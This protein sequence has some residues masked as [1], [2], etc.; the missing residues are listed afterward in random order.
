L[1][2][3]VSPQ[4][5]FA[6]N[7]GLSRVVY[8]ADVCRTHRRLLDPESALANRVFD[9]H[10]DRLVLDL[11]LDLDALDALDLDLDALGALGALDLDA[12][13]LDALDLDALDTLDLDALDLDRRFD[14]V[15]SRVAPRVG[16]FP[17][18]FFCFSL[19]PPPFFF[20]ALGVT[21]RMPAP[22]SQCTQVHSGALS[23]PRGSCATPTRPCT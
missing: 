19:A 8:F 16:I 2:R 13:D 12:L 4:H 6:G 3:F 21:N 9:V 10:R 23:A 1:P 15:A 22:L 17:F 20:I 5:W 7:G 18:F 14:R 11:V